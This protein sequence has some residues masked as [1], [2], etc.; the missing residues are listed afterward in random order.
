MSAARGLRQSV[1]GLGRGTKFGILMLA[2]WAPVVLPKHP[3][4]AAIV[5]LVAAGVFLVATGIGCTPAL[6]DSRPEETPGAHP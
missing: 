3:L 2:A 1:E 5:L 4:L 6:A